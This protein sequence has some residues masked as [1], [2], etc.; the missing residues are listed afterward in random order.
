M[1]EPDMVVPLRALMRSQLS[2][3]G[4]DSG[5]TLCLGFPT[6]RSSSPAGLKASLTGWIPVPSSTSRTLPC[7]ETAVVSPGRWPVTGPASHPW[8]PPS[9]VSGR[10]SGPWAG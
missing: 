5:A 8:L 3:H 7:K 9:L 6:Q 4:G 2:S 10:F 1:R